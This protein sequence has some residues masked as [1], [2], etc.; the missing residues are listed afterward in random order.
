MTAMALP[1]F[2]QLAHTADVRLA[3]WGASEVELLANAA[4]GAL[5]CALERTPRGRPRRWIPI[6][7]WPRALS[8]RLVRVV[9]E[10]L[11]LLYSRRELTVAVRCTPRGALLGVAPLP[12][13]W[14]PVTEVKAATFHALRPV[15]SQ[16]LSALLTL[17]L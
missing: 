4:A 7:R 5:R 1:R 6:A 17:D 2:R 11:F 13:G 10:A 15:T 8:D 14:M 12:D 9:N 3:V 16:R